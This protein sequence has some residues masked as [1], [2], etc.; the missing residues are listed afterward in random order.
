MHSIRR[1]LHSKGSTTKLARRSLLDHVSGAMR[2]RRFILCWLLLGLFTTGGRAADISG[3]E[4]LADGPAPTKVVV[5]PVQDQISQ[6]L[7]YIVRRGLKQAIDND[8]QLVVLDM[9]TPGGSLAVTLEIMEA[10]DKFPGQKVTFVNAEAISAGAIIASVT[11]DIYF[12]PKGIMG[13][14]EVVLGTG[15]DVGDSMKRKLN[16]YMRAKIQAFSEG[17][18]NRADIIRAMMDPDFE[19]KI[20][21]ELIKPKGEL[22]SLTAG[23]AAREYGEPPL[24]LLATGV[25]ADVEALLKQHLDGGPFI[26]TRLEITWSEKVAQ[27]LTKLAPLLLAAGLVLL[28]IEFKTP[29]FGVFGISGGLLLAI[30]FFGH[31]IAGFSGH[32]P[33]LLFGIGLLL[34]ALEIFLFPGVIF[35]AGTGG[36][37]LLVALVWSMA[38]LWPNEPITFSGD[39]FFG[40][41][42][43]VGMGLLLAVV[44]MIVLLRFLPR[45]WIWDRLVLQASIGGTSQAIDAT[46]SSSNTATDP[47]IGKHGVAVTA[48]F[49]GG[50][51][52]INGVRYEAHL[53]L[54]MAERGTPVVVTGRGEFGLRVEPEKS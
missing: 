16:S 4:K 13:A 5:I 12:A 2:F 50:Q 36:M 45:N 17:Q 37:L 10:L 41:I 28:F 6:P 49:P 18:P 9:D 38:D 51:V 24:P 8:V 53:E 33:I 30:V 29:G 54:G 27:Y 46:P 43:S 20:G 52:E 23:E 34:I 31:Y 15:Q 47:L 19:L 7:L 44:M 35:L 1:A 3:L 21:E 11:D 26:I 25:V 22:L 48:L 14:A 32:E 42:T 40:P 39:I